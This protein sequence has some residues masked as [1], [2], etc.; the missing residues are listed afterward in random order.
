MGGDNTYCFFKASIEFTKLLNYSTEIFANKAHQRLM[1]N[2]GEDHQL[3]S[4]FDQHLKEVSSQI[5]EMRRIIQRKEAQE[6]ESECSKCK[7][8]YNKKFNQ[9]ICPHCK[10]IMTREKWD[11]HSCGIRNKAGLTKCKNCET[12]AENTIR[13]KERNHPQAKSLIILEEE[14][15]QLVLE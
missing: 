4:I 3:A 14:K 2:V 1:E 10:P 15:I 11:C 8:K 9:G 6:Y 12:P 13:I 5:V 7:K